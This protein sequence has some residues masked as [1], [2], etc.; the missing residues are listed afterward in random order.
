MQKSFFAHFLGARAPHCNL[1]QPKRVS[2]TSKHGGE[3]GRFPDM[4]DAAGEEKY[5][6]TDTSCAARE[7]PPRGDPEQKPSCQELY[8]TLRRLVLANLHLFLAQ[9]AGASVFSILDVPASCT[10]GGSGMLQTINAI[11]VV[12]GG[13]VTVAQ[14]RYGLPIGAG[15]VR[16]AR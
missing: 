11:A 2:V 16:R 8:S 1:M 10:A 14:P 6:A 15:R 3:G 9:I 7:G 5:S 12:H 4:V 13:F